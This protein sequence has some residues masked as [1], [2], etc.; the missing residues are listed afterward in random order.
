VCSRFLSCSSSDVEI[1][2]GPRAPALLLADR[3]RALLHGTRLREP[4]AEHDPSSQVTRATD[5]FPQILTA[6]PIVIG[7]RVHAVLR[8]PPGARALVL[9]GCA[10]ALL[11]MRGQDAWLQIDVTRPHRALRATLPASGELV[12]DR[13]VPD[14]PSLFGSGLFAQVAVESPS[15]R[16]VF[17]ISLVDGGLYE[18]P[19]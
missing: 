10:P 11:P 7:E 13:V 18:S 5:Q 6:E 12:I 9:V 19:R 4:E 3:S 14:N 17:A 2:G 16:D 15:T 1:A 8:G